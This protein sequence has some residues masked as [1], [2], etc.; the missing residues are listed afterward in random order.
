[1]KTAL[2]VNQR[3]LRA[4]SR[5]FGAPRHAELRLDSWPMPRAAR[6]DRRGEVIFAIRNPRGR[7]L[8]H[9]KSFYP[10]GVYRLPGGGIHWDEDVEDALYREVAEETGLPVE[11]DRFVGLIQNEVRRQMKTFASY[12]FLLHT[13]K[14]VPRVQ[15]PK[16]RISGFKQVSAAGLRAASRRLQKLSDDWD[17]W[18]KFR[19]RAHE[20]V[21]EAL[22]DE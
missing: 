9:T 21:L 18:G 20:L 19:A 16:E 7:I 5:K 3:E 14:L 11:V 1:M 22:D 6:G 15:D 10:K 13:E 17:V 4:L 2:P 12:V 8:L